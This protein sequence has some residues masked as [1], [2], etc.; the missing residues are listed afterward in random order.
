MRFDKISGAFTKGIEYII[1]A[2]MVVAT[3]ILVL[4]NYNILG[5]YIF[6]APLLGTQEITEL[7]IVIVVFL[8]V[9]YTEVRRAHVRVTVL[10][11]R[12]PR[13]VQI[14][15]FSIMELISAVF[16][17]LLCWQAGVLMMT[18]LSPVIRHTDFLSI[19]IWPFMLVMALGWLLLSM[20]LLIH[21]YHDLSSLKAGD[22]NE[23]GKAGE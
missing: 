12:F 1:W 11:E 14:V 4:I 21:L 23:L 7:A 15:I 10:V 16:V 5:R 22:K 18:R 13:G 8:V 19:P 17:A 6:K 2:P 3:V 20:Q 9:A